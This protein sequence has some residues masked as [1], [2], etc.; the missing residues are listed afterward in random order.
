MMGQVMKVS[1]ATISRDIQQLKEMEY[2]K[3]AVRGFELTRR[4]KAA[5]E[6]GE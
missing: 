6:N 5:V 2:I 3:R 1:N 4:G